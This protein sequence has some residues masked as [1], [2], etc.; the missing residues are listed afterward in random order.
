MT[1]SRELIIVPDNISSLLTITPNSKS[2]P[3]EISRS[4]ESATTE[5]KEKIIREDKITPR[6]ITLTCLGRT[7]YY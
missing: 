1:S 4:S 6:N 2:K 3:T 7:L 5:S